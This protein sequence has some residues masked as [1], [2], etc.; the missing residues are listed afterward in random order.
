LGTKANL[1]KYKKTEIISCLLS[2]HNAIKQEHSNKSNRRKCAIN[3]RLNDKLLNN[4]LVIAKIRVEI[5][6]HLEL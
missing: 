4:Q 1:K 3:W 2:D 6:K 5:I